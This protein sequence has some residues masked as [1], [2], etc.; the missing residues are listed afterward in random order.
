MANNK[1]EGVYEIRIEQG[2]ALRKFEELKKRLDDTRSGIKDLN[3]EVKSQI[4]QEQAVEKAIADAGSATAEQVASLSKLKAER[5]AT[6]KK[7]SEAVLTEKALSAQM[8]ELSN[9]LSGLTEHGLRFRDKMAQAT[10]IALQQSGVIE[11]LGEQHK[12]L[13]KSLSAVDDAVKGT[14]EKMTALADAFAKSEVS[15]DEYAQANERLTREL[16][17][18]KAAQSLLNDELG[19]V[20]SRMTELDNK[21]HELNKELNDGKISSE[22]YREGL[23]KIEAEAK[24][25]GDATESLSQRFDKFA[26]SQGNELKSSLS[27]LALNYVG[28]GAAV[29]GVQR[30]IGGAMDT[31]VQF[32]KV[33]GRISA[34]GGEYAENIDALGKSSQ[35]LG[36]RF[37]K[38]PAEAAE[39]IEA[40]AKAGVSAADIMG[41]A[42]ESALTL[43]ASGMMDAGQAAEYIS[44]TMAQF[45]IEGKGAAQVSDLLSAAANKAMGDVSDFGNALKFVG[46]VA[47]S[48]N[49]E[50]KE[51]VGTLALFAQN[52]ILGEQAGTSLRGVLSSLTSPS[53]AATKT[54]KDLGVVTEDGTNKLYDAQGNFLG[55]ANMAGVLQ[56]ATAGLTQEQKNQALGQIF[57]NQQLTA[58]NILLKA[59]TAEV[60][61]WTNAVN[62]S[63]IASRIA[64]DNNDTLAG[65]MAKASASWDAMVLN[66]ENGSGA[67]STAIRSV[68]DTF[69]EF[70]GMV[71][72]FNAQSAAENDFAK[73]MDVFVD[74]ANA[75]KDGMSQLSK[76]SEAY[77]EVAKKYEQVITSVK[78]EK[79]AQVQLE[80]AIDLR[81]QALARVKQLEQ[82]IGNGE[83]NPRMELE[84]AAAR[85]SVVQAQHLID[86]RREQGKAATEAAAIEIAATSDSL[87]ADKAALK[88]R[89]AIN[90]SRIDLA[91]EL[92][93]AQEDRAQA[94]ASPQQ[95]EERQVEVERDDRISKAK[96][97]A[98]LLLRVEAEYQAQLS[99][100]R[101]RYAQSRQEAEATAAQA[102][103]DAQARASDASLAAEE[104]RAQSK[105][106][107]VRREAE[108]AGLAKEE[109]ERRVAA[110]QAGIE[111]QLFAARMAQLDRRQ[112]EER[113]RI[114][115][116][117]EA[118]YIEA[119]KAGQDRAALQ[120]AAGQELAAVDMRIAQQRADA[121]QQA[122]DG[123]LAAQEAERNAAITNGSDLTAIIAQQLAE[124]RALEQKAYDD[125]IAA[126]T[127]AYDKQWALADTDGELSAEQVEA[128]KL[129]DADLYAAKEEMRQNDLVLQQQYNDYLD[130]M[131][132]ARTQRDIEQ[133]QQVAASAQ[134]AIGSIISMIDDQTRADVAA[135][136]TR[137]KAAQAEGASTAALE[138]EKARVE[139][140]GARKR[141]AAQRA[142]NIITALSSVAAFIGQA[143]A[144]AAPGDPYTVAARIAAA[145]AAAVAAAASVYKAISA[146]PAYA[147]GGDVD[148][149]GGRRSASGTVTN[150]WGA[151]VRRANGDNVLVRAGRGYVTLKTGEKVLNEDQQKRLESMTGTGVWGAIGLPGYDNRKGIEIMRN[152]RLGNL[153]A[154]YAEGGTIGIVTPRP[155]PQTIVQNQM[156]SGLEAYA[157]RPMYVSVREIRDVN[158]RVNVTESYGTL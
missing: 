97:D 7:L 94:K 9:D 71:Q 106:A 23:R 27:S 93:K 39:S 43:S 19:K 15:E 115:E 16:T 75:M 37:G 59:G 105:V 138:R 92:D 81:A 69:T 156:V 30:I 123:F 52:G 49:I 95:R 102:L 57:G 146:T 5:E 18:A 6:N 45:G 66:L 4:A 129:L 34:L 143:L 32:D 124:R 60:E 12:G 131:S 70:V 28:V 51:T 47:A 116:Q 67:I 85:A 72:T 155:S 78:N 63:G 36:P 148:D 101:K 91:K 147:G 139:A 38:G 135:I 50:L 117:Y 134:Q 31:V 144:A 108:A 121:A 153:R 62:D 14:E 35:D 98:D 29:Y 83:A 113:Q 48:N 122:M 53:K 112:Q 33:L 21:V 61:N 151:P 140:E 89:E 26:A 55:L 80:R 119:E 2:P 86:A 118:L 65:S 42:L 22:Q 40:L 88:E 77:D 154:G 25:A 84:L 150:K 110:A 73:D 76:S 157:D 158:D 10:T 20:G 141:A 127:E 24:K 13:A 133:F 87:G 114:L 137:I 17:D 82:E 152:F 130:Q 11:Q 64:S 68:I 109:V 96:G 111:D 99:E 125:K 120:E 41:G 136:D 8:R 90:K 132:A 44:S 126:L 54:L 149:K 128:A 56:D 46:P 145:L 74:K 3:K 107:S 79:D 103:R 58:A 100:I 1:I 142:S 104:Q